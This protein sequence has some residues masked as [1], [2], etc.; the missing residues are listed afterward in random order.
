MFHSLFACLAKGDQSI[1]RA[2]TGTKCT[3][4]AANIPKICKGRKSLI[5]I[6]KCGKASPIPSPIKREALNDFTHCRGLQLRW[7]KSATKPAIE[8]K[9][10]AT[11]SAK[12]AWSEGKKNAS[13]NNASKTSRMI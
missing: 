7:P 10:A 2:P 9:L 8:I 6:Q 3:R 1:S 4:I 12:K 13:A 5:S 11:I